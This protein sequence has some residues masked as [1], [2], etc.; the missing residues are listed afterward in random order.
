MHQISRPNIILKI[1]IKI[2]YLIDT[3][4][5]VHQAP[6]QINLSK[7]QRQVINRKVNSKYLPRTV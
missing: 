7:C 3:I 2:K 6:E 1:K 4:V 5:G